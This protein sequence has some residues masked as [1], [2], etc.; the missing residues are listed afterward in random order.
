MRADI[1]ERAHRFSGAHQQQIGC[2]AGDRGPAF[3][4]SSV[5][6]FLNLDQHRFIDLRHLFFTPYVV[7]LH[8]LPSCER[9][10]VCHEEPPLIRITA[11]R[12]LMRR[13]PLAR[14]ALTAF[15][16][17]LI[18]LFSVVA[19]VIG[20]LVL[21]TILLRRALSGGR[22]SPQPMRREQSS[23]KT[24]GVI[25]GEYRVIAQDS[26]RWTTPS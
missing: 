14:V 20:S 22:V 24:E 5:G 26:S 25:E 21:A 18:G 16:L 19:L 9:G 10:T 17:L 7:I 8:A 2:C 3:N 6:D 15:G 4:H 11:I 1:V 13:H 23:V 12:C